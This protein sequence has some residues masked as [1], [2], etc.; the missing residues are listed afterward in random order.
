[1][2]YS[3]F[4]ITCTMKDFFFF[5][6]EKSSKMFKVVKCHLVSLNYVCMLKGNINKQLWK[7]WLNS[8]LYLEQISSFM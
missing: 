6:L 3:P 1:M 8:Y 7:T 2:K 4:Q 5:F